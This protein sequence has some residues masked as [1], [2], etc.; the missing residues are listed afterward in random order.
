M[1]ENVRFA[2]ASSFSIA[3]L[4][5]RW[6][7]FRGHGMNHFLSGLVF[8]SC[9]LNNT[10]GFFTGG[11]FHLLPHQPGV[12]ITWAGNDDTACGL[13]VPQHLIH[14]EEQEMT[15][16]QSEGRTEAQRGAFYTLSSRSS[17]KVNK[18]DKL[19]A[20]SC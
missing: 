14:S 8:S 9:T 12:L 2:P 13:V 7:F 18:K 1:L 17:Q 3:G 19:E 20:N 11:C 5:M 4:M 10:E 6:S 15:V 16:S